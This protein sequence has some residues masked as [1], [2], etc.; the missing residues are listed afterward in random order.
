MQIRIQLFASVLNPTNCPKNECLKFARGVIHVS[1]VLENAVMTFEEE[2]MQMAFEDLKATEK[3][4]ESENT[5]VI[6]AIKNKIRRNV[7]DL[8]HV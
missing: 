6:E 4:C 5:G 3:L 7:S 8:L 1:S 2:K